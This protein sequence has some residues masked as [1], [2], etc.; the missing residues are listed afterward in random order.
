MRP[1]AGA[2]TFEGA[3]HPANAR[4]RGQNRDK[5]TRTRVIC[6]VWPAP[7]ARGH[8]GHTAIP[9]IPRDH[10]VN[11]AKPYNRRGRN[12][13]IP[14]A[15]AMRPIAGSRRCWRSRDPGKA[16]YAS[17]PGIS[18]VQ[19]GST[20][21]KRPPTR[22]K[23]GQGHADACHLYSLARSGG[24]RP[25][26]HPGH[27][28]RPPR[29]PGET[30][31]SARPERRH[32]GSCRYAANRGISSVLEVSTSRKRPLCEQSRDL[33]GSRGLDIP[34]TPAHAGNIE[35]R[36]RGRVSFVQL[37]PLR[38]PAATLARGHPATP[39]DHPVNRAKPYNRR[40]RNVDI[41]EAAA[42]RPIA[43]SRRC[44][45][46]RDP[47]KARYASNPGISEVRGGSTSRKRP[48]TRVKSR[49]GHA[50]ACHL[51]S[52]ARSGGQRPRW[53]YGHPGPPPATTPSTGRNHTIGE[54][55]T[56][57]SRK[58]PLCGQSR[59]LVGAGG[60]EIPERPAMRAIPGSRR[61]EGARHPAN[62]RPRGQ[63]RDKVTR[64]RVICTVWPAPA[65]RGHATPPHPPPPR[66]LTTV[67]PAN[68]GW[69]SPSLRPACRARASGRGSR[70]HARAHG[71]QG[72]RQS[73]PRP[74]RCRQT[75]DG[76]RP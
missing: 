39:R 74:P 26:C 50:D 41:P 16:R 13:D 32:P 64:T 65:A 44:W 40:G 60:L 56:S 25:R 28:P 46:S 51:Y 57:T 31:Q 9:A 21:R 48:P 76:A 18:E 58:L 63:N 1:I 14:E 61:F 37:G 68:V 75:R 11:R 3:R 38:R 69:G 73:P 45:R 8:A 17:N 2:R 66:A 72:G 34:Q 36:S 5:V 43:G 52:L 62:T 24:P 19:G 55:E 47:G 27:P 49:Q 22:A 10:P 7:A 23:S 33:R 35:T 6:T 29:Q 67:P 70:R 20:S 30:I 4:P 54:A 71:F 53:A 15:A 12:V 59:D 42:M